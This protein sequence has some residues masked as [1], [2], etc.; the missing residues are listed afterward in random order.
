[1]EDTRDKGRDAEPLDVEATT[2]EELVEALENDPLAE[3]LDGVEPVFDDA[4]IRSRRAANAA[5]NG[6]VGAAISLGA[7][8]ASA[9]PD[10]DPVDPADDALPDDGLTEQILDS[11]PV[12]RGAFLTAEDVAVRLPNGRVGQRDVLR[13][14]GGVAVIALTSDGK[15]VLVHQYRTPLEQVTLEIPAGKL[16]PGEDPE[17]AAARELMEETGYVAARMAYLGPIAMAPGYCDEIIHLYMAVGLSFVGACPD[18]DEFVHV[19]LVDLDDM[20]DA[21]LDG[22]VIDAKTVVGVMLCDA[23]SRRMDA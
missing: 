4:F 5:R 12:W 1:M 11:R 16:V 7:R 21:V 8:R 23:I 19:D 14:P 13:H 17:Q 6:N 9:G 22:K 3:P 18:D 10:G 20:V 2:I 15:L